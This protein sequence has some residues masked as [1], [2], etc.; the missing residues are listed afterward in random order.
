MTRQSY[1]TILVEQRESR[2]YLT[3]NR[4]D[5]YNA[6]NNELLGE[7][8]DVLA[9][10]EPDRS[11][12][13][14][15][16]RGAGGTFCA[17]GD[18]KQFKQI[19][20]S[21]LSGEEAARENRKF[22][23]LFIR[24]NRLPQTVVMLIEGAAIGGGFGLVCTSD[25]AICTADTRFSLS[26]TSL[27]IVPAQISPF[28]V[29]RLGFTQARRLMLTGARFKGDE[30]Q[31]LGLVHFSMPSHSALDA[32]ADEILS[33]I[34]RCGPL[35]S[36]LTKETL[37]ITQQPQPLI[38]TLDMASERFGQAILSDE[39]REGISAFLEKRKPSWAERNA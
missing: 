18:L 28:V 21:E 26:E 5:K 27:G 20:L 36:A 7:L 31:A 4:P 34:E 11:I 29:Q 12:Q 17:G 10:L 22:G 1:N 37:H 13:T 6:L 16:M 24:L 2:C 33:Q 25:I 30:A 39:G 35:A 8:D 3:L 32:K 14:L 19:F 15:I 38:T 23:D 9:Q